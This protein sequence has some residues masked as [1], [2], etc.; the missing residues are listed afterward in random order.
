LRPWVGATPPVLH[1]IINSASSGGLITLDGRRRWLFQAAQPLT[2]GP[3]DRTWCAQVVRDAVGVP[4]LDVRVGKVYPW[5]MKAQDARRRI[6]DALPRQL[7]QFD[8]LGQDLGFC[9]ESGALIPDGTPIPPPEDRQLRFVPLAAP[10]CRAPHHV[11][12]R[13]GRPIS[14]LD[15]FGDSLV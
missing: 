7:A 3:A 12:Y 15:L 14:T 1:W 6:R 4:D 10:G 13:N 9:Y 5:R 2:D 11:L 8:G